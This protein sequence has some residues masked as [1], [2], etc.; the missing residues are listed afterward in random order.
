MRYK[1]V[2][3]ASI[4]DFVPVSVLLLSAPVADKIERNQDKHEPDDRS[5]PEMS[6]T[7]SPLHV[8][9]RFCFRREFDY[10]SSESERTYGLSKGK[11]SCWIANI[12]EAEWSRKY[13]KIAP[14]VI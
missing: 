3:Q 9:P 8:A 10:S 13:I 12:R 2:H 5:L 7:E 6:D 14:I 1:R 4:T 11:P